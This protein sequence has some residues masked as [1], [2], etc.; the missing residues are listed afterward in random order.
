MAMGIISI[1]I[2]WTA[3]ARG[4]TFVLVR[5][6]VL[7]VALGAADGVPSNAHELWTDD[8]FCKKTTFLKQTNASTGFDVPRLAAYAGCMWNV[9][10]SHWRNEKGGTRLVRSLVCS[11]VEMSCLPQRNSSRVSVCAEDFS[12]DCADRRKRPTIHVCQ[13]HSRGKCNTHKVAY[14]SGLGNSN[15]Y[16]YHERVPCTLLECRPVGSDSGSPSR[17][18]RTEE[19][20]E[21][22]WW[23]RRRQPAESRDS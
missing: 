14:L 11:F 22:Q 17:R 2:L 3:A 7:H 18:I 16:P 19:Q 5:R 1:L 23:P 10:S 21:S 15:S 6:N 12:I 9:L 20:R 4:K 13:V 8:F